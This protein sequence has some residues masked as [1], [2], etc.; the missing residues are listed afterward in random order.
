MHLYKVCVYEQ[1]IPF[2]TKYKYYNSHN[3]PTDNTV[4]HNTSLVTRKFAEF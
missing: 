3:N 4:L 1:I 2:F